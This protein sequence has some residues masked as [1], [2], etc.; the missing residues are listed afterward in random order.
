[1]HRRIVGVRLRRLLAIALPLTL[2]ATLILSIQV[3]PAALASGA[4]YY[5]SKAG[6]NADGRSWAT[7]WNELA[8]INWAIVQPGDTILLDGGSSQMVYT[9]TLAPTKSG[10]AS[11]PITIRLAA[12]PGRDGQVIV[13]GGRATTL[14]YC[15]QPS[16]VYQTAGVRNVGVK[17]TGVSY[18][19]LDGTKWRGIDVHGH[20]NT[21]IDFDSSA[22]HVTVRNVEVYDNG[23][24]VFVSDSSNAHYN[25]WYPDQQGFEPGGDNNT[26]E[27]AIVHDNGQDAFQ[28]G[29][30]FQNFAIRDS[31]LYNART[32]PAGPHV[33]W[34]YCR[35]SDGIQVFDGG[36]SDGV[37]IAGSVF[38]PGFLQGTLLGQSGSKFAELHN[39]S[40]TNTLFLGAANANIM[41]YTNTVPQGWRIDHVTSYLM[42]GHDTNT[43]PPGGP[44]WAMQVDGQNNQISNSIF[45]GGNVSFKGGTS[46]GNVTYQLTSGS[47][48]GV[49]ADPQFARP[50]AN[51]TLQA[52]IDADYTP[53]AAAAQGKGS[54]ITSVAQLLGQ[55]TT[56][57]PTGTPTVATPSPV[58]TPQ[59]TP[60]PTQSAIP[61]PA[62]SQS[63]GTPTPTGTASAGPRPSNTAIATSTPTP[64]GTAPASSQPTNTP[65]VTSTPMP[66]VTPTAAATRAPAEPSALGGTYPL[67]GDRLA[68]GWEMAEWG[69]TVDPASTAYVHS[70]ESAVSCTINGKYGAFAP[71]MP[72][73]SLDVAP[74]SNLR[75]YINGEATGGQ[76]LALMARYAGGQT[77]S[78]LVAIDKYIVGGSV[79][80]NQWR[81]VDV[82]LSAMGLSSTV[83][84]RLA[85]QDIAG[86]PQPSLSVDD[87]E[88]YGATTVPTP[89]PSPEATRTPTLTA[90][91]TPTQVTAY[92]RNTPVPPAGSN[93]DKKK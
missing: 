75:F 8:Q 55:T 38:G 79:A 76:K 3:I 20:N 19:V 30:A 71:Y 43:I 87:I 7:A 64:T 86:T 57:L 62:A 16:Y 69:A 74:Y 67:Y 54:A 1:M 53:R 25:T 45:Q 26:V 9:S 32:H 68:P 63:P 35:H 29:S 59:A 66:S 61:S 83:I 28:T 85:L 91:S 73:G 46:A 60:V 15:Y 5:V 13:F 72:K 92:P 41:G 42:A 90:T 48:G 22:S 50:P 21:G 24:A 37:T 77:W 80:A 70:G 52:L 40:I 36:V 58:V 4:T 27:R 34:N 10:T 82:P 18:V 2:L 14:P 12:D 84:N 11:A 81:L 6:S 65:A 33:A 49:T 31:W 39:V 56:L 88:F 23:N 44:N 89:T 47:L 51:Y 93:R 78:R 17:F